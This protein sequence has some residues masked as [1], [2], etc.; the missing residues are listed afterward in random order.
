MKSSAFRLS[1]ILAVALSLGACAPQP[2]RAAEW[3][4]GK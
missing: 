4:Q 3:T 1:A 2:R